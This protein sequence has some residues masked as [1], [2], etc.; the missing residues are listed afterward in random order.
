MVLFGIQDFLKC[1]CVNNNTNKKT[2]AIDCLENLYFYL[3]KPYMEDRYTIITLRKDIK[4]GIAGIL[5]K[6]IASD[7]PL[8]QIELSSQQRCPL[9]PRKADKKTKRSCASCQRPACVK[10]SF[11]ICEDCTDM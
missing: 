8:R 4:F 6:D 10:H 7:R 2:T 1:K 9:C 5:K 11:I 3:V